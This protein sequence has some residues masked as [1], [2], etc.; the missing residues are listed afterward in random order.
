ML[1][2]SQ[3]R[4]AHLQHDVY[5]AFDGFGTLL[6]VGCSLDIFKRLQEH[7]HYAAWYPLATAIEVT[8]YPNRAA[9]LAEEARTIAE[10]GPEFNVT[11]ERL[12]TVDL[13]DDVLD[14]FTLVPENGRWWIEEASDG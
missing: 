2:R 7:K 5:K 11:R 13:T 8:R 1:N 14:S 4:I 12:R 9:A 6:Y 10:D 3:R